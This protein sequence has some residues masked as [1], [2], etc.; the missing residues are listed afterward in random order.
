MVGY[1]LFTVAQILA[2]LK[3][4]LSHDIIKTHTDNK[5]LDK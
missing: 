3:V 4:E 5:I 2:H 1:A